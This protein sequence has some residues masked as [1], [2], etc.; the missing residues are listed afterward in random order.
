[1]TRLILRCVL[2]RDDIDGR[3]E[4]KVLS[5]LGERVGGP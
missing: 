2:G 1:M 4:P 5:G 3:S